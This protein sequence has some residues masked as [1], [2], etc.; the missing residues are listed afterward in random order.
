M[1]FFV[2]ASDAFIESALAADDTSDPLVRWD[3]YENFNNEDGVF[4]GKLDDE[5]IR[6]SVH[7]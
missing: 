5:I 6:N 2:S 7:F 1:L 4:L 3:S